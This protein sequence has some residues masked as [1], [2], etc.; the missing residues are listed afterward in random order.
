[1][2]KRQAGQVDKHRRVLNKSND[3]KVEENSDKTIVRFKQ[4]Y[5]NSS[6]SLKADKGFHMKKT[7]DDW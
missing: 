5:Q 7:A 1:M 2:A 6:C 4:T 3:I